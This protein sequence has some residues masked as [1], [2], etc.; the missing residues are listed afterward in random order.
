MHMFMYEQSRNVSK[1]PAPRKRI[2]ASV[3]TVWGRRIRSTGASARPGALVAAWRVSEQLILKYGASRSTPALSVAT[4]NVV[5]VRVVL[6]HRQ[7]CTQAKG[8]K[9]QRASEVLADW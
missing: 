3:H 1:R 2:H 6:R 7:S 4:T 5:S 8:S 9:G